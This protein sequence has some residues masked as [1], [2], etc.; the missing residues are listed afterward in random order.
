MNILPRWSNGKFAEI[1]P[2]PC[3]WC[4]GHTVIEDGY[5]IAGWRQYSWN[6]SHFVQCE[7]CGAR[8]PDLPTRLEAR[9]EWDLIA[10]EM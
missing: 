6:G 2:A 3:P 5:K 10:K 4:G 8:G 1:S 7:E 9:R